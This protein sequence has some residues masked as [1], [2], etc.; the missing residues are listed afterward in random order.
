MFPGFCFNRNDTAAAPI[1][2]DAGF[3]AFAVFI[4]QQLP[5]FLFGKVFDRALPWQV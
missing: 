4:Y 1:R 2:F 5:Q 3:A